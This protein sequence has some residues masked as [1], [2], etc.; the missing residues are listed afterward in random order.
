MNQPLHLAQQL[1]L[2]VEDKL[3]LVRRPTHSSMMNFLK[4]RMQMMRLLVAQEERV[5]DG[6]YLN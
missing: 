4:G 5:A 3:L 1:N 6:I 2:G